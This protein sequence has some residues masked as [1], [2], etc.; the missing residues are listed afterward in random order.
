MLRTLVQIRQIKY[1]L[2]TTN[3]RKDHN[4]L[5]KRAMEQPLP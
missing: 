5:N 4:E 3:A 1:N 2:S